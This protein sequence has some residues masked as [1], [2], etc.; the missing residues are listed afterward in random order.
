MNKTVVNFKTVSPLFEMERDGIKPFTTRL[1][2]V[3]DER[4]LHLYGCLSCHP[5]ME[6]ELFITITNPETRESFTRNVIDATEVPHTEDWHNIHWK[7]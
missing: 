6:H 1:L 2:P 4:F 7:V 3:T 5:E